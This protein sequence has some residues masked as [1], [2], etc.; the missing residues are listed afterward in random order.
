MLL[1][2]L[3]TRGKTLTHVRSVD[4]LSSTI[5]HEVDLHMNFM[6]YGNVCVYFRA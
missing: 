5:S 2:L 1:P 6:I 4:T 3:V